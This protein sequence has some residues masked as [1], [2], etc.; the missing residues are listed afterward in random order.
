LIE[1]IGMNEKNLKRQAA[2]SAKFSEQE[3]TFLPLSSLATWR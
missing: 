3:K 2:K 1:E